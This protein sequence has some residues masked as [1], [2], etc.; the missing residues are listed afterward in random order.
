MTCKIKSGNPFE[1][2]GSRSNLAGRWNR[3]GDHKSAIAGF[4]EATR[5]FGNAESMQSNL[6][7]TSYSA[8]TR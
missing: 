4:D 2:A 7:N 8:Q 1:L 5:V 3:V 6:E